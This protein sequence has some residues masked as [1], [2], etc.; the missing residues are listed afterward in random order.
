MAPAANAADTPP[1]VAVDERAP[2]IAA[3]CP[4]ANQ[5][6]AATLPIPA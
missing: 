1:A 5:D 2:V 6:P 3:D 4:N